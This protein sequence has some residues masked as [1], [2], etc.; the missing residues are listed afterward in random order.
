MALEDEQGIYRLDE[1]PGK[2]HPHCYCFITAAGIP[3]LE[4]LEEALANGEFD[5]P[6]KKFSEDPEFNTRLRGAEAFKPTGKTY[7]IWD[8]SSTSGMFETPDFEYD[9]DDPVEYATDRYKDQTYSTMNK[10]LR[11]GRLLQ[12]MPYN[13]S[14]DIQEIDDILGMSA[15]L[16]DL[17]TYRAV[18]SRTLLEHYDLDVSDIDSLV[19]RVFRDRG[20]QSTSLTTAAVG[21]FGDVTMRIQN[22]AGTSG[23]FF[24]TSD[25]ELEVLLPRGLNMTIVGAKEEDGKIILDVLRGVVGDVS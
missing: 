19:G 25:E 3:T 1:C 17:T 6:G 22:P 10:M 24:G 9:D 21:Q 8:G 15:I 23:Y 16:Q 14:E 11:D 18:P 20:F 7:P 13:I 5:V 12:E 4:E 2:P